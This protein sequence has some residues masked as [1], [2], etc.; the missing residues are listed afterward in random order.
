[1]NAID[2]NIWTPASFT[3]QYFRWT[4]MVGFKVR[5]HDLRHSHATHLPR[6]GVSP[7]VVAERLGHSTVG[8]TLDRYSHVLKGMQE[9]AVQKIDLALRAAIQEQKHHV[10]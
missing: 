3:D 7:K 5:F 9:E 6:L 1:M 4:R 8:I 2:G 10:V